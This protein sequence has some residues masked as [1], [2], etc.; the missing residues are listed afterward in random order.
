MRR[1]NDTRQANTRALKGIVGR[2]AIEGLLFSAIDATKRFALLYSYTGEAQF[3]LLSELGGM[4]S[5]HP[6][7]PHPRDNR[8]P[9]SC[10]SL[11]GQHAKKKKKGKERKKK[12][13]KK[14]KKKAQ[15][16]P[17]VPVVYE[18][19]ELIGILCMDL[20][21][22]LG[23]M[24]IGNIFYHIFRM[25]SNKYVFRIHVYFYDGL[26]IEFEGINVLWW[27]GVC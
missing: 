14:E 8:G 4:N 27:E 23:C 5:I 21:Y 7:H 18:C 15:L 3:R 1:V 16:M 19:V 20:W 13:K 12:R 22:Q 9:A 6:F 17:I 24:V 10:L 11:Q 2:G 25:Y 26:A